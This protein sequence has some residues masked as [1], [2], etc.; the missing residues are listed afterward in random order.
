MTSRRRTTWVTLLGLLV[1]CGPAGNAEQRARVKLIAEGEGEPVVT[2]LDHQPGLRLTY[3]LRTSPALV[4]V[5]ETWWKQGFTLDNG[6]AV[7][8]QVSDDEDTYF[9]HRATG[10][11]LWGGNVTGALDPPLLQVRLP[12]RVG[13][14]WE[15]GDEATP[16]WYHYRVERAEQFETAA[17][18]FTTAR[19]Y[20]LNTKS[21]QAVTRWYANGLGM[22]GRSS[23]DVTTRL[24]RFVRPLEAP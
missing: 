17:G 23:G 8:V 19:V 7:D 24:V 2:A 12:L 20:Q 16:G 5:S 11:Y 3:E 6:V 14:E 10:R 15:T 4:S 1:G 22:V 9:E 21:A 18:V 13:T